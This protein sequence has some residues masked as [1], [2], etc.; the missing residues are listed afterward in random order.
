MV[1]EKFWRTYKWEFV[2]LRD[3]FNTLAELR[4]VTKASLSLSYYNEERHHQSLSYRTPNKVYYEKLDYS[5]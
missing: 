5:Y 3:R 1:L 2:Y 4:E